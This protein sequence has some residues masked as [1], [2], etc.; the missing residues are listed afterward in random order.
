MKGL[1]KEERLE[2]YNRLV[3]NKKYTNR[4]LTTKALELYS[5]KDFKVVSFH[6]GSDMVADKLLQRPKRNVY[7][8]ALTDVNP[9]NPPQNSQDSPEF[10]EVQPPYVLLHV[11]TNRQLA[12]ELR[13]RGFEVEV[14]VME[15]KKLDI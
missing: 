6:L 9:L 15:K 12:N 13:R 8:K 7:T 11:A 1:N 5:D 2:L 4:Q 3:F 14:S 10:I